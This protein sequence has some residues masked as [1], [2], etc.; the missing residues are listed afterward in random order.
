MSE[1][2]ASSY[3]DSPW[4]DRL[5]L[6]F[7]VWVCK[8]VCVYVCVCVALSR[9]W[10]GNIGTDNRSIQIWIDWQVCIDTRLMDGDVLNL[11]SLFPLRVSQLNWLQ[12]FFWL[13]PGKLQ[14]NLSWQIFHLSLITTE[15]K[16]NDELSVQSFLN[17]DAAKWHSLSKQFHYRRKTSSFVSLSTSD[18]QHI[19]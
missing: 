19:W 4:M 6:Y 10:V 17:L 5:C 16:T 14:W 15:H 11:N 13:S 12:N 1:K 8:C 9:A 7:F 18:R 2:T 3:S